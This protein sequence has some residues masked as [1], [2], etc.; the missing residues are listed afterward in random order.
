MG[1]PL[2]K[3][4]LE[5]VIL[6]MAPLALGYIW[7]A[8]TDARAAE[9][10]DAGE[11]KPPRPMPMRLRNLLWLAAAGAALVG[12][13]MVLQ[14]FLPHAPDRGVYVPGEVRPGGDVTPGH[15]VPAKRS[16]HD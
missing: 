11:A 7:R 10:P 5:R 8:V 16:D 4:I 15:F 13:S 6:F 9:R 14:V 1:Q 12:A 2:L 3:A